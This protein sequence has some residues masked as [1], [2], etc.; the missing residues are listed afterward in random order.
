MSGI[1]LALA[2]IKSAVGDLEGNSRRIAEYIERASIAGADVVLF[3][4]L[5]LTGYPPEDLLLK[6]DFTRSSMAALEMLSRG[7]GDMIAVVGYA[8]ADYDIFNSAAVL[9][10]GKV[11]CIYRKTFLPNYGVFDEKRY[12]GAGNRNVVLDVDGSRL[13]VTICEDIWFPGGPVEEQVA[14][15][16]AQ[17]ILNLSASPFNRGKYEYRRRL[18]ASRSMDGPVVVA[19]CN[20]VGAQDELVFD[21]GS[22]VYHPQKG[23]I[24]TAARFCEELLLCEI[25]LEPLK[26]NRLLEPRF[27]YSR[28]ECPHAEVEV[29]ALEKP[30]RSRRPPAV[31]TPGCPDEMTLTQEIFEAIVLGLREYV[32]KNGF[33]KVVLGLS[34]GIDSALT[35]ALAVEALGSE[36]VTCV[37]L[38]ST[39]TADESGS[40]AEE[41]ARN[42]GV[43]Y[44]TMPIGDIYASYTGELADELGGADEGIAFENLQARIRGNLLMALSNQYGWLVLAT[45]NK[46][47]LSMGYCTL[48][49]DM[50]GGFALIKDL[51]KTQVYEVAEHV[52]DRAGREVIP[53]F[54]IERPPTAEL[55]ADQLDTDSLPPY[56]EL[57]PVLEAYVEEGLGAQEIIDRGFDREL[58]ARIIKTVDANEYKRRQAPVGVKL[59]PRAFGRDWRMPISTN[60][61]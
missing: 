9:N 54:I 2:Q 28:A 60:P 25:D 27:R 50:A 31:E 22:C 17:I 18:I 56:D 11:R 61:R 29:C 15:G 6:T 34:G 16:G 45:G 51:L 58:V 21:G 1:V 41:L 39:F 5:C 32:S 48:Y 36:N 55:R 49:G 26:S 53:R 33:R 30:S 20:L 43:K 8:E 13:G 19:Y 46:S 57:D 37:F 10:K 7:V 12:F 23:F 38:P 35:A 59:T 42:L 44:V 40:A 4:E 52:N 14:R 47:E 24:A 3:P